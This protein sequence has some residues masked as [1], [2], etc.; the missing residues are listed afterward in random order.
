MTKEYFVKSARKTAKARAVIKKGTGKISVNNT[1]IDVFYTGYKL[2]LAKEPIF[3]AEDDF[4][5][6]NC[7]I[8]VNGGGVM[9][10]M[11]AVRSCLAKGILATSKNK[12]AMKIKFKKYNK[13]L[14]SDPRQKESKK[15]LGTGARKKKQHS[16]R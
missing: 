11:Q 6:Y 13:S 7:E 4:N 12:K 14:L 8:N 5:N 1:P 15:Q 10:Q 16:K 3:L 9:G 2:D